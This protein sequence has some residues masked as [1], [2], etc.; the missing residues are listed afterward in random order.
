[1]FR[2][3]MLSA[4]TLSAVSAKADWIT[5]EPDDVAA[6]TDVTNYWDGVT[7]SSVHY[8]GSGIYTTAPVITAESPRAATGSNVFRSSL[9]GAWGPVAA[10]GCYLTY[11]LCG[12]PGAALVLEFDAAVSDVNVLTNFA[13][14]A[15]SLWLYDAA[16][17]LVSS[18]NS[19]F[20]YSR[21]PCYENRGASSSGYGNN[22]NLTASSAAGDV[23]YAVISAYGSPGVIDAIRYSSVPEPST[24]ALLSVGLLGFAAR[25]RR[26]RAEG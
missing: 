5:L 8:Q 6:G 4:L 24:I 7:L 9:P 12:F 16:Y 3:L 14:D 21:T 23:R 13:G 2:A 11:G 15:V 26:V 1:M 18:C 19:T 25:R 17:N 20:G 10:A 22:W